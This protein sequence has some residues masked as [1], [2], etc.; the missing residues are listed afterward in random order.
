MRV[1]TIDW[2]KA[3]GLATWHDGEHDAWVADWEI[4]L[5]EYVPA[6]IPH[7]DVVLMEDFVIS[8]RTLKTA[9]VDGWKR[10]QELEFIGATKYMCHRHGVEWVT[11]TPDKMQFASDAKLRRIGWWTSGL[12]H[13]RA[14]SKH[15][16]VYLVTQRLI[17]PAVLLSPDS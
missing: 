8:A 7:M 9:S 17:D 15:L 11:Q 14:A 10:G 5:Y 1:L 4:A 16:L 6:A 12:D 2:G 3:V 13:S